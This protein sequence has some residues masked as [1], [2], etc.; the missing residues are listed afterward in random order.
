MDRSKQN[1]W[2]KK[3]AFTSIPKELLTIVP[4]SEWIHGEMKQSFLKDY[5][6]Q[7]IHNGINLENFQV[8]PADEVKKRY[9]LEGKRIL[10]GVASI[11]MEEKGWNDFMQLAG[12][13][14]P[15]EVIVL[16]GVKEEQKKG[17]PATIVPISRTDN[18]KQLAELY[19]AAEA[20]VNPTWQ[21]NYPTVNLEAIACG[22]PVVTYRTGGSIE[23]IT[24]DTGFIVEQGDIPGLLA[25]VRIIEER[26]KDYYQ[27]KCRAYAE[28][29]FRKEDRYADY[30]K[31]YENLTSR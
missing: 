14:S 6:Y 26:G 16:V 27:T 20:L 15:N 7:V 13:L 1:F 8:Y 11:W 12:M 28:A 23:V 2:D 22:T 18:L 31:L 3:K 17:L 4:V 30:L 25:A 24:P 5:P 10:L 19:A 29:H 21:D 9:G